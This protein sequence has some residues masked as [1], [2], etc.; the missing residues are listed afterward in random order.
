V[1]P[2]VT[3]FTSAQTE[4]ALGPRVYGNESQ[5]DLT[6][7]MDEWWPIKYPQFQKFLPFED[8]NKILLSSMQ[9]RIYHITI[10]VTLIHCFTMAFLVCW[11][12]FIP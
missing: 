1:G 11:I 7:L 6:L 5:I 10:I 4:E 2:V 3:P 9:C 12:T 8:S